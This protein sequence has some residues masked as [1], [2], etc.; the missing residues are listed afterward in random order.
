MSTT[1]EER[2][3]KPMEIDDVTLAFP[4]RV[5]GTLIPKRSELPE[6]YRRNWHSNEFC[7][8]VSGIFFNGGQLP[9]LKPEINHKAATRHMGAVLGSFEPSTEEKIGGAGFLLSLWALPGEQ[10][11]VAHK[12]TKAGKHSR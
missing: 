9:P 7:R 8:A 10:K 12:K 2:F 6:E 5:V 3:S 1:L 11:P 4:A